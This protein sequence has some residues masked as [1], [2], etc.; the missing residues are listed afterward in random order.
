MKIELIEINSFRRELSVIVPFKDLEEDYDSEVQHW[1]SQ[2][3]PRGGRKGKISSKTQMDLFKKEKQGSIDLSFGEK[4]M[5]K[6]YQKALEQKKMQPINKA[7]ITKLQFDAGTD[8][9]FIAVFEVLPSFKLPNYIKKYKIKTTKYIASDNDVSM[10]LNEL[11]NNY[12]TS[13]EIKGKAEEGFELVVDYQ[14][15]N[16]QGS[17]VPGRNIENQKLKLGN[18]YGYELKDFLGCTI[19]DEVKTII[20]VNGNKVNFNFVIKKILKNILPELNDDFAKKIDP[21]VKNM[22]DLKKKIQDNIQ[23]SLDEQHQKEINNAVIDYFVNK[24]KLEAPLSMVDN[25]MEYI[26]QDLKQ[27]NNN[28]DENKTKDEYED[29]ANNNVK[30]YLIKSELI[31]SNKVAVSNKDIDKKIEEFIKLNKSQEKQIKEFY[32]KDEN[33]NNLHEQLLND[34]L[35]GLINEF[36]INK[37]SEKSTSELKKEK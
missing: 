10:S 32:G 7:E 9:E 22:V 1:I 25:Y 12:S 11:Q 30:W 3:T 27:K 5:N 33:L 2:H 6:F 14:E 21:E 20:D 17:L 31:K 15:L 37:I 34:K 26:I 29:M 4:A 35:F 23:K 16:D 19:G 8:L 28:L 13:E 36:A 24:T 18:G